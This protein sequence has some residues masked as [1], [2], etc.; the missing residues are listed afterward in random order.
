MIKEFGTNLA[1]SQPKSTTI[2]GLMPL[3]SINRITYTH[4]GFEVPSAGD[5]CP[6]S[7]LYS[8]SEWT[9]VPATAVTPWILSL[10]L[11]IPA[12]IS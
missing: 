4:Q 6:D 11:T 8:F 2:N 3:T 7:F 1:G 5:S 10:S 12:Q 9:K